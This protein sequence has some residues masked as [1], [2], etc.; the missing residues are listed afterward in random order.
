MLRKKRPGR[1]HVMVVAATRDHR[2]DIESGDLAP[3]TPIILAPE[4]LTS[5][6]RGRADGAT[7]PI[8]LERRGRFARLS[9]EIV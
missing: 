5:G 1:H 7:R 4:F 6:S 2:P 3:S 9:P 8:D